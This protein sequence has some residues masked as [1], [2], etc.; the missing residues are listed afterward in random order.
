LEHCDIYTRIFRSAAFFFGGAR[1][2]KITPITRNHAD[3]SANQQLNVRTICFFYPPHHHPHHPHFL[4][5]RGKFGARG[6]LRCADRES[7]EFFAGLYIS[8][9]CAGAETV[10]SDRNFYTTITY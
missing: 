1:A 2:E 9:G 6:P 3:L 5:I 4:Q 7:L 10:D 8:C